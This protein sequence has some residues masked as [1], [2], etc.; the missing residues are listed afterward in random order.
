MLFGAE[1]KIAKDVVASHCRLAIKRAGM[2]VLTVYFVL[3]TRHEVENAR[4]ANM[5]YS[6]KLTK[7]WLLMDDMSDFDIKGSQIYFILSN[8]RIFPLSEF[9]N[10]QIYR[11]TEDHQVQS[12]HN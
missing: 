4:L 6:H 8:K 12:P 1:T 7:E 10:L 3:Y 5:K 2:A 11:N 9:F